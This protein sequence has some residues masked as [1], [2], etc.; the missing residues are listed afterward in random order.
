[1]KIDEITRISTALFQLLP[2]M[3]GELIGSYLNRCVDAG[4]IDDFEGR[5]LLAAWKQ[6]FFDM[7]E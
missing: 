6:N 5:V 2:P 3:K 7:P 4:L 1:M